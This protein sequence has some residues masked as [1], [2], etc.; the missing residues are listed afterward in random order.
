MSVVA[1]AA[2]L[3]GCGGGD[4]STTATGGAGTSATGTQNAALDEART[5]LDQLRAPVQ[6]K[7]PGPA[8]DAGGLTG[9]TVY[10]I[11]PGLSFP[12]VQ[13][14]VQGEKEA[15]EALGM[16]LVAVDSRGQV[17]TASGLID[18]AVSRKAAAIILQS[19]PAEA[20]AAPL[21][22]AARAGIPIIEL[23]AR[24]PQAPPASLEQLGIKGI[25]SFCYT[26]A[27]RQMASVVATDSG[28]KAN[29]V[30]VGS[31]DLATTGPM[32]K[33]F[34]EEYTRLCPG[35]KLA[36]K[37]V[38]LVQWNTQLPSLTSSVL[39]SDPD[40]NYMVPL[41]DA[42]E[43]S[44]APSVARTG[45]AGNVKFVSYNATLPVMQA[46]KRKDMVLADI[47]SPL[48]WLGWGAID[49]TARILSGKPP[50]ESENLPNRLFDA[51]NIDSLDLS[52]PEEAWYGPADFRTEYKK[53]WGQN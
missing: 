36:T 46:L 45:K 1:V 33:A 35:C 53:L 34:T 22:E 40:V 51:S 14:V 16:N 26:C 28:G 24:D 5:S 18:Q 25:V 52:K 47:G 12:F 9:K 7:A 43:P 27:A 2:M 21:K 49:Q 38:Q 10:A 11:V 44:M 8:F 23:T 37:Q 30:L 48:V 3:A 17:G 50:V 4:S 13:S 19:V 39:K 29:T 42:M 41:Y 20:L 15:A 32:L 31:P 6:F